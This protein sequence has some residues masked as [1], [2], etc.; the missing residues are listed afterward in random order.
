MILDRKTRKCLVNVLWVIWASNTCTATG[1]EGQA[2]KHNKYFGHV[3]DR[4][5]KLEKSSYSSQRRAEILMKT[6]CTMTVKNSH[7][8]KKLTENICK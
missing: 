6:K 2:N 4:M 3:F 5:L 1:S 8:R 7:K